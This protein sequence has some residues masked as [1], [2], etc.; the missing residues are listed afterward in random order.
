[1][2]KFL[3]RLLSDPLI[4]KLIYAIATVAIIIILVVFFKRYLARY[5]KDTD[6]RYYARKYISFIGF[7]LAFLLI[8]AIFSE[9]IGK[10]TVVLGVAGAGVAFALQEVIASFAGWFAISVSGFYRIGD[11]VQL[12]GIKGDVIDIGLL[13]STLMECGEWV[14]SDQ[15]TGRIVRIAN[16]FVF[17]EPVFNYSGDFPFLWDEITVPV[18][19]GSDHEHARKILRQVTEETVGDYI[20]SAKHAWSD[21]LMK[22]RIE[23]AKIEPAVTIMLNDNWIEFSVRYAVDYKSRR[24]VK[25]R[26]FTRILEEF[27]RTDGRVSIASTTLHLVETPVIDVRIDEKARKSQDKT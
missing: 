2:E 22:F 18:K 1:M 17:K 26:L 24:L 12:G 10:L 8:G 27:A 16:S 3:E 23:E 13:R 21:M 19:Y 20:A 6:T 14:K 5:I 7:V 9:R 25:D 11:R 15:Y 4:D